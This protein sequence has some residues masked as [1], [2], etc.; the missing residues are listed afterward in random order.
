MKKIIAFFSIVVLFS[1]SEKQEVI[2][3]SQV[4]GNWKLTEVLSDPG[5]ESGIFKATNSIKNLTFDSNG[6]LHCSN[7]ICPVEGAPNMAST[8]TYSQSNSTITSLNCPN[9][10]I[11]YKINGDTLILM[12]PCIEKCQEKYRRIK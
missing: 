9:L 1:C 12:Y 6:I 10:K 5:D 2:E 11:S 7:S 3:N 4:I 8:A